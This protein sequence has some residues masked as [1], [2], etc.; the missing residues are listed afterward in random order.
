MKAS[1]ELW[2]VMAS[3]VGISALV[4][5]IAV[6]AFAQ[7][8]EPA[9]K[10]PVAAPLTESQ[11]Q[12][13]AIL[14]RMAEFLAGAQS[15]SVNI[16]DGYD[17]VQK[18]GQKIE[19]GDKRKVVLSRPDRLRAEGERSDG[20][21]TQV[22]FNGKDIVLVDT[23]H[24]VYATAPQPGNVDDTIVYFVRDL[25]I[26]FP[27]ARMLVS[28]LPADLENRVQS[29]DY[30]EKT[31][32]DGVPCHHLA[33][34][35]D[36]VDFQVWVADGDKPL[37]QRVVITYKKAAGQPQFWAQFSDWDMAPAITDSTFLLQVDGMQKIAF[38]AQ[39]PRISP[40]ARKA[41]PNKGAK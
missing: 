2:R 36:T 11:T 9:K 6:Q 20:T 34:R 12:G 17:A 39:L 27:L 8:V 15:F 5:G 18:S 38:A 1:L 4:L 23:T 13:H 7:S 26:R 32:I 3:A 19:F 22:V 37:P 16:R 21:K 25:G 40:A 33:A 14:M 31:S 29:V 24:N 35:S 28:R 10:A 41:S 30:V